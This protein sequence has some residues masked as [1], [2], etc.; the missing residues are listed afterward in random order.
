MNVVFDPYGALT[1][2][3]A[4]VIVTEWEEVCSVDLSRVSALMRFPKLL[5]DGRNVLEPCAVR[6]AGMRYRGFG[7]GY[8]RVQGGS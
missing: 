1:G 2:A 5:V 4:A 8:G 7:R 6:A 3:H